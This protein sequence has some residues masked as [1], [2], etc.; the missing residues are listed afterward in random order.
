[1]FDP[2]AVQ[3]DPL[4]VAAAAHREASARITD[5]AHTRLQHIQAGLKRGLKAPAARQAYRDQLTQARSDL[6]AAFQEICR[7][8]DLIRDEP[9]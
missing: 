5:L 4:A 6:D 3:D 2:T 7:L 1:M 9:G 8:K